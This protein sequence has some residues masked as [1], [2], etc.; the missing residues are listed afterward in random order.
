M[1]TFLII[2]VFCFLFSAL[3]FS[4]ALQVHR[5]EHN[6]VSKTFVISQQPNKGALNTRRSCVNGKYTACTIPIPPPGKGFPNR[7]RPICPCHH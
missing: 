5:V 1:K 7:R 2:C 3:P 4:I 6:G